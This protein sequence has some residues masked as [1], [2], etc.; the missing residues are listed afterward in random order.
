MHSESQWR[1]RAKQ[2]GLRLV[3]YSQALGFQEYGPYGLVEIDTG[4]VVGARFQPEDIE[5]LLFQDYTGASP[6]DQAKTPT[7]ANGN[8]ELHELTRPT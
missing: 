3:R 1:W 7:N 6:M 8:P 4:R 2:L 5:R